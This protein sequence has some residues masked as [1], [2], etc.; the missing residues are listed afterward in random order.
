MYEYNISCNNEPVWYNT[1]Y[2][3]SSF[4]RLR[5][6]NLDL[7]G[8]KVD[9]LSGVFCNC[10]KMHILSILRIKAH[11]SMFHFFEN[12]VN[13]SSPQ[14]RVLGRHKQVDEILVNKVLIYLLTKKFKLSLILYIHFYMYTSYIY[15]FHTYVNWVCFENLLNVDKRII[16]YNVQ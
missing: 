7:A 1:F 8:P 15:I 10:L 6:I 13:I 2:F 11:K 3:L 12:N 16:S 5:M 4:P 14:R 9:L